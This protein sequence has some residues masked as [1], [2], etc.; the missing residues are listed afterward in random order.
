MFRTA[1]IALPLLGLASLAQAHDKWADGTKVPAW[2]KSICCGEGD[3]HMDPKLTRTDQGYLV[4]NLIY[5]KPYALVLPSQDGHVWAFYNPDMGPGAAVYC[6][7]IPMT[8][9]LSW[10]SA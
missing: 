10:Q 6:L 1:L 5:P 2:V 3:A 7:F 8:G 9:G 4:D